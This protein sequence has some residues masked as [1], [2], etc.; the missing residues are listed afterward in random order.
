LV[1]IAVE[2]LLL[3]KLID[4]HGKLLG[5]I[6]PV[7]LVV[8]VI[9][10]IVGMKVFSDYR[11]V[12]LNFKVKTAAIGLL[13]KN[14]PPYLTDSILAGQDVFQDGSNVYLGKIQAAQTVPAELLLKQN[15]TILLV[16][17]PY[18]LDLRLLLKNKC[19]IIKGPARSGV[20]LG[21]LAV[22]VGDRLK[23]HTLY[24]SIKGEIE[25]IKVTSHGR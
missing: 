25:F 2:G 3:R 19:R 16:K 23:A 4:E 14:V 9:L 7:D 20:Y 24:T 5:F 1:K 8:I 13:V 15:G 6:N 22:R 12:P 11:P 10:L 18:R 21:K 17:S